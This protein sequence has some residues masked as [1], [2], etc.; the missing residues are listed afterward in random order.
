[1]PT[2][3]YFSRPH[4]IALHNLCSTLQPPH[5]LRCLLGLNLKFCPTKRHS[6]PN[7]DDN[8]SR[9]RRD[10]L[11]R[12]FFSG[13]DNTASPVD[14]N[15]KLYGPSNWTPPDNLISPEFTSRVNRFLTHAALAF[16][17]RRCRSN[18]LPQQLSLLRLLKRDSRFVIIHAD[19]NL[20]PCITEKLTY[21]KHV[22]NDHL[23]NP[24]NYQQLSLAEASDLLTSTTQAVTQWI[25]R[26]NTHLD[27]SVTHFLRRRPS[28]DHAFSRFYCLAKVHKGPDWKTRPIVSV[29]GSPLY[30]LGKWLDTVLQPLA[31]STPTFVRSSFDLKEK[32]ARLPVLS[33]TA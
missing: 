32:L 33:P 9:F 4:H 13:A 7:N 2:W 1:M 24:M 10:M 23:L 21:T 27:P 3:Y 22:F 26:Y 17:K 25:K 15:P 12:F 18:L 31:H 20:G 8:N 28:H 6:S 16:A 29:C 19:K 14:Y 11:L 30:G 5:N